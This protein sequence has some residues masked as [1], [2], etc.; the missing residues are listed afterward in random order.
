[1]LSHSWLNCFRFPQSIIDTLVG[2]QSDLSRV[3]A[4]SWGLH[5]EEAAIAAYCNL[6]AVV[7]ETGM[8]AFMR[9]QVNVEA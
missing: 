4:V 2:K 8:L 5:H 6:G 3:K 9:L 7:K 1:M